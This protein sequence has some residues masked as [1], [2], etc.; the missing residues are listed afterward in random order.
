MNKNLI[1]VHYMD[2]MGSDLTV[3][4][5]ARVSFN[6]HTNAWRDKDYRLIEYLAKHNHWSPFS[7]CHVQ[8]RV[9]A[10]IFVAR[11][12][13]KHQVGMAWNEVSRRYVDTYPDFFVPDEWRG[14]AANNKQGS[15]GAISE[16]ESADDILT[17]IHGNAIG[18]YEN[19]L[20]LGVAPEQARMVLPQT[21]QT[22]WYWS[23]SLYAFARVCHQRLDHH[24]QAETAEVAGWIDTICSELFPVSWEALLNHTQ[25]ANDNAH[26]E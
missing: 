9:K 3:V 25:G 6:A 21:T 2:S 13:A 4:N 12:L 18:S 7:H 20:S 17:E 11:Q 23:G 16:Q 5:A 14:R 26:N 10:P 22:E 24:S 8:F 1:E 15:E 19:L